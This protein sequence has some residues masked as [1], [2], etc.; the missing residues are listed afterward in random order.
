[1]WI[2]RRQLAD[3]VERW[4]RAGWVTAEGVESIQTEVAS[5]QRGPGFA[6]V[7]GILGVVLLGFAL[8]SFVAANWQDMSR[9]ARLGIIFG[10]LIGSY[11]AAGALYARGMEAFGHAA[12]L[13]GTAVFGA[14]I[15]LISQMYHIEGNPPDAV[16]VWG[17]GALGAGALLGSN[18]AL[19][20]SAVLLGLWSGWQ[21]VLSDAPHYA[22]LPVAAILAVVVAFRR[23]GTGAHL[24]ALLLAGWTIVLGYV[25]RGGDNHWIVAGIGLAVAAAGVATILAAERRLVGTANLRTYETAGGIALGYGMAVALAG[26]MALQFTKEIIPLDR[27]IVIAAFTLLLLVAAIAFGLIHGRRGAVWLGYIG[28][29]AEI[30]ALYFKTVGSLLGSSVFFLVAGLIVIALAALAWRLH[31]VEAANAGAQA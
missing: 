2:T 12:V 5:R 6:G 11:A 24:V 21:T 1:M 20:A 3:D 26:L 28:F 19:G 22:L 10:S 7:L 29:S 25:L 14:G 23:W 30:L 8:M 17:L 27:L 4:H 16:L 9:L 13:L 15:M 18:P 31:R